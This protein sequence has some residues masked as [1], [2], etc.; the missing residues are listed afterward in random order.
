MVPPFCLLP[1]RESSSTPK[2][3][4][5]RAAESPE[6][7]F[8]RPWCVPWRCRLGLPACP[9][10][11]NALAGFLCGFRYGYLVG[12]KHGKPRQRQWC[13]T[14]KQ[15]AFFAFS[16]D[17]AAKGFENLFPSLRPAFALEP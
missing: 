8:F 11:K 7:L 1:S 10:P 2:A 5:G 6:S 12:A 16:P 9:K 4:R 3:W 14:G 15:T 13:K 17:N